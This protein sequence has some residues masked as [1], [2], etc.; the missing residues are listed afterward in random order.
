[1]GTAVENCEDTPESIAEDTRRYMGHLWSALSDR[2]EKG[3]L[4]DD[5]ECGA[6][7]NEPRRSRLDCRGFAE[8]AEDAR[9]SNSVE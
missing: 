8:K 5:N 1:M 2:P 4:C 3:N 6:F 9:E 7:L